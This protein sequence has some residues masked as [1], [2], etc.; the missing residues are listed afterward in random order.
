MHIGSKHIRLI[1]MGKNSV[2]ENLIP[3]SACYIYLRLAFQL[4]CLRDITLQVQET[5]LLLLTLVFFSVQFPEFANDLNLTAWET[6][7]EK[8]KNTYVAIHCFLSCLSDLFPKFHAIG[9]VPVQQWD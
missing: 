3:L 9:M 1:E 8:L 6:N 4:S 5:S 7:E 2:S